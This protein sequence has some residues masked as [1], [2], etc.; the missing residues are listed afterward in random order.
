MTRAAQRRWTAALVFWLLLIF[1]TS[2]YHITVRQFLHF[3][4]HV[5]PPAFHNGFARF[6]DRFWWVFV[7]GWHAAEFAI[8]FLLCAAFLRRRIRRLDHAVLA[9]LF[10]VAAYAAADEWHQTF[11][12]G[13]GGHLSDVCIDIGG[14]CTAALALLLWSGTRHGGG[15][16]A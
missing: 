3:M 6:W 4:R 15:A 10:V 8:L 9:S 11:V 2:S 16:P 5:G 12:P 13:R 14:A 7:K 1:V